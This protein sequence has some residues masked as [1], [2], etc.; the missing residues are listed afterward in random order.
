MNVEDFPPA[1][2]TRLLI[3][4]RG[5]GEATLTSDGRPM[6]VRLSAQQTQGVLKLV[7]MDEAPRD[8]ITVHEHDYPE[9]WLILEGSYL[10]FAN[11]QWHRADA[12][13]FVYAPPHVAHG[14]AATPGTRCRKLSFV[15]EGNAIGDPASG[16]PAS[17][18][19]RAITTLDVPTGLPATPETETT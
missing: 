14:I 5:E 18:E 12:G 19:M 9:A 4:R 17:M 7:E 8:R 11:D 15:L 10:Y 3:S 13:T 2:P 1:A 6:L 16:R